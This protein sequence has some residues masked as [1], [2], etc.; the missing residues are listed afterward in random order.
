[1]AWLLVAGEI[2]GVSQSGG[3][4]MRHRPFSSVTRLLSRSIATTRSKDMIIPATSPKY[5]PKLQAVSAA[6]NAAITI[7]VTKA[8]RSLLNSI[9]SLVT[10]P[11][12]VR[13]RLPHS[14]IS[15]S[16]NINRA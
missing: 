12:E 13:G 16:K 1:M 9:G 6:L 11:L 3:W 5:G 10:H 2:C 8:L 7:L 15:K 14:N 4:G